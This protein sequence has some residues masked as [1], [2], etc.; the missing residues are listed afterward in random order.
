MRDVLEGSAEIFEVHRLEAGDWKLEA[1][2]RRLEAGDWRLETSSGE[3]SALG[4]QG[5]KERQDEAINFE[6]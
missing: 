5:D 3:R 6:L 4:Q 1:G 2:E